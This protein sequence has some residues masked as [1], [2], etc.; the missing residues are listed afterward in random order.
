M[1]IVKFSNC[2]YA[3]RK[4]NWLFG[5]KYMDLTISNIWWRRGSR[6]FRDCLTDDVDSLRA[7]VMQY[8]DYGQKV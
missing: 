8:K 2:K 7:E 4:G 5:Y 6:H 1:E 3:I